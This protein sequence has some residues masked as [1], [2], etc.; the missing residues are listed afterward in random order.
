[1]KIP[2]IAL[3]AASLLIIFR[4]QWLMWIGDFLIIE[5][6]LQ[7]ADV[8]HIIAGDDYRTD[9]AI[10]LYQQGYGKILFFTGGWC[11]H[12]LYN[13][14]QHAEERAVAR[15]LSLEAIAF[16]ESKVT[17]TYMEAERLKD[18]ITNNSY[19][20]QSIIVV[21]DPFH[22]RRV[23]WTYR[24]VFG[25]QVQIQMAPVSM[26]LT[27]YRRVWWKDWGSRK[28]V[29]EEYQKFVY[30]L[31]RYQFSEGAFREWLASLDTE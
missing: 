18:W 25:D 21:S 28:Y 1:M 8:I 14:G 30:Y 4:E 26:E 27:P 29:R 13:H 23:G 3:G 19:S 7:P 20:V 11:Q 6:T 17:S 31:L 16:D 2:L 24:R 12:H 5:D 9:Y 15:G 10:Q 22:M